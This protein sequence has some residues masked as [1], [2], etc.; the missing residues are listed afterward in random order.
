MPRL[1]G[2]AASLA[3]TAGLPPAWAQGT[4]PTPPP[5]APSQPADIPAAK[6]LFDRHIREI[7][8]MDALAKLRNREITGITNIPSMKVQGFLSIVS[9]APNSLLM[10]MEVPPRGTFEFGC[11]G[12]KAWQTALDGK[13]YTLVEPELT[14][15]IEDAEFL[16][17]AAY[18][19]RY[20]KLGTPEPASFND[21]LAY[22]VP[23]TTTRGR[24]MSVY[25][26][27]ETGLNLGISLV[28]KNEAGEDVSMSVRLRD[29]KAFDGVKLPTRLILKEGE[30]YEETRTY[31][32][33][34]FNVQ[35]EPVI[36]APEVLLPPPRAQEE[37][38]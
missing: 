3:L 32:R 27:V 38:G 22:R 37:G 6:E 1:L 10:K 29:Y 8:G 11:D 17:E 19:T 18:A 30:T 13:S 28:R 25:F 21:R 36:K 7:G 24:E 31:T 35:P 26:D 14:A 33:V 16:G 20:A 9:V 12:E 23:A 2:L 34:R 15:M 4:D 5:P